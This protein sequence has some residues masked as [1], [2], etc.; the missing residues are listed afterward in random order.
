MNAE[1][2]VICRQKMKRALNI[3][4]M[5]NVIVVSDNNILVYRSEQPLFLKCLLINRETTIDVSITASCLIEYG[6]FRHSPLCI[7]IHYLT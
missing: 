6:M 5:L 1:N 2:V 4:L 3:S 7:W